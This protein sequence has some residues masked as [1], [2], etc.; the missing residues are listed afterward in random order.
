M[1]IQLSPSAY[2]ED[3]VSDRIHD[4]ATADNHIKHTHIGDPELDS[5]MEDIS[6]LP[7][8]DLHRF[9]GADIEQQD[10]WPKEKP[11]DL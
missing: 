11:W 4:C 6:T 2:I 9:I 7:S 10:N 8:D 5:V 1:K 3:Y